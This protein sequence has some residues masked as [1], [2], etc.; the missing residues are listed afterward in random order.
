MEK[1]YTLKNTGACV[2][3]NNLGSTVPTHVMSITDAVIKQQLCVKLFRY[4]R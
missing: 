2:K 1:N 3:H 4:T